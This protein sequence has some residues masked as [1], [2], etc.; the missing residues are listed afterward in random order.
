LK[1]LPLSIASDLQTGIW[2]NVQ[3]GLVD[4]LHVIKLWMALSVR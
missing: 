4:F 2:L 1:Q 3:E